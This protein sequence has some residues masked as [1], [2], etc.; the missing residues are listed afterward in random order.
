[1]G[2]LKTTVLI[3]GV[4]VIS[5]A[6]LLDYYYQTKNESNLTSDEKQK[7]QA[8]SCRPFDSWVPMLALIPVVLVV[9]LMVYLGP[10]YSQ[11]SGLLFVV[12]FFASNVA[13]SLDLCIAETLR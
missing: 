3:S 8:L 10:D 13:C 12:A 7:L 4:V 11:V 5:L 6:S 2:I 1:M 9:P